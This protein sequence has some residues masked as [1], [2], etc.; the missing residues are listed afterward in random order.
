MRESACLIYQKTKKLS[1]NPMFL[2][3]FQQKIEKEVRV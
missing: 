3:S 1:K 2:N